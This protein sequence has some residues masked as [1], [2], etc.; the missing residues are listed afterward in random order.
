MATP[1]KTAPQVNM[2]IG[3]HTE[4]VA[5]PTNKL[6]SGGT[7]KRVLLFYLVD[8]S[9]TSQDPLFFVSVLLIFFG[10]PRERNCENTDIK[11]NKSSVYPAEK[12]TSKR[13]YKFVLDVHFIINRP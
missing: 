10:Q 2:L 3:F 12:K 5:I 11:G 1:K 7:L 4:S 6:G 9:R 13:G 8:N